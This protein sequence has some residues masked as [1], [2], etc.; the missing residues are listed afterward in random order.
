MT[1][2]KVS[3]IFVH[4]GF[5]DYSDHYLLDFKQSEIEVVPKDTDDDMLRPKQRYLRMRQLSDYLTD[6]L[7]K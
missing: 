2:S 4:K 6:N 5:N 3:T 7:L 1:S